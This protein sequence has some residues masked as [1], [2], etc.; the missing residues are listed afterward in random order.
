MNLIRFATRRRVTVAM[1]TLAVLLFGLVSLSRLDV[2]LLPDLAYPTLTVRT[3][4]AGA[5]PGEIENLIT[6]PIEEVVG[7]VQGVRRVRSTSRTG[8]SD[9]T[10][11]FAWGSNMDRAAIDVRERIERLTLP[12]QSDRP[13]LLRFDPSNE[14]VM[15]FAL[16]RD[17]SEVAREADAASRILPADADDDFATLRILRRHA[18]ERL[19][20]DMESIE[21]VAA[22]TVSGGL[23]DEIQVLLDQYRLAQLNLEPAQVAQRLRAENINLS[24]GRLEE[25]TRQFLVR[26]I[27]E[28][29]SVD[30]IA[31]LIVASRDG[32]PIY[33]RDIAEVRE[34]W[35]ERDAITRVDGQEM[36]ELALYREGDANVVSVA[37]SVERRLGE[38]RADLPADLALTRVYDQSVFIRSAINEVVQAAL[39]GGLLA[40][41]VLY[42]FLK[43]ARA[44]VV[45]G[46]AIPISV[47]ATF[48]AMYGAGVTLNIMSLGGIA[49]AIGLLVDNAIVVLENIAAK[50]ERGLGLIAA[51]REGAGE[52]SGAVVAATLT[53]IAVFLPLAFVDGIAGQLFRDQALTVTF[54]LLVSLAVAL[55][56]IPMLASVG[57]QPRNRVGGN[58]PQGDDDAKS[59]PPRGRL[60]RLRGR[61]QSALTWLAVLVTRLVGGLFRGLGKGLG[62]A[63]RPLVA[64]FNR[65]YDVLSRRYPPV[66]EASLRRRGRTLFLALGLFALALVLLPRLGMELVPALDQG[67]LRVEIALSPGTPLAQTGQMVAG[68]AAA[69]GEWP[70]VE[71]TDALVG[72]GD[73]M[74]ANPEEAGEH[75]ATLN[76]VLKPGSD[77]DAVR[78]ALRSYLD[79]RP[80]VDYSIGQPELFTLAT[81]LEV[82][83][84][85][86]ELAELRAVATRIA[87]GMAESPRFADVRSSAEQGYPEIRIRF[88]HERAAR[89]GL[90]SDQIADTVV[91][92]VRGDVATR[93]SWREREIDVRVRVLDAQ[94]ASPERIGQLVVNPGAERPVTL[95]AVADIDIAVGPGEI[96][97]VG[98]QRVAVI[99]AEASFGD[100]GSAAEEAREII[101]GVPMPRGVSARVAGQSEEMQRAFRSLILALALAV[102]L[103]YLVMASQFESLLHPFVILLSI[104]LAL[105]GAVFALWLTGTTLSVVVFIGVIML[106]GIVVNNAIVLVT[107]INQ[108]RAEGMVREAAIVE[109]GRARLRPIV[110]TTLTTALGLLPLAVGLGEGAEMRAPM[111]IA[112]IG[113]LL[114]STALTLVVIPVVYSLLDRRRTQADMHSGEVARS[115]P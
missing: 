30:E 49:L 37:R 60:A 24:G 93:Y 103:V 79:E 10:L 74:D 96:R 40:I 98:Q 41:G 77:A 73:R 16:A 57:E 63:L 82:E 100:L 35:R 58:L 48:A 20:K 6:R 91:R 5:A 104:P 64:V 18:D 54:A 101:A 15:R 52:V 59:E 112:V 28:F 36:V 72:T 69:A 53:T 11:E 39:F 1:F 81:P 8:Q 84:A 33:L 38:I 68:L 88:D 22:I 34:G 14:P 47:V 65:G 70:Q 21:G 61:G 99:S 17:T 113:G 32:E 4:F 42:L 19:K 105:T 25:G 27:N 107:R 108:L 9:V 87:A 97:R 50:R 71:R 13:L 29:E 66:L 2:S 115:T 111:A 85:G 110:M 90:R 44:T 45:V 106:A 12:L 75:R 51:A 89:L 94:R 86:Y 102:F 62:L 23:E 26:T 114:L 55:T 3:E 95:D 7:V 43:S 109:A 31:G 92:Q 76:V 83:V 56:L 67:E 80:G 46:L 78:S